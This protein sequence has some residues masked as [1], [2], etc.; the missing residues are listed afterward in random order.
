MNC[1]EKL[2]VYLEMLK[3]QNPNEVELIVNEFPC[4][5]KYAVRL[6]KNCRTSFSAFQKLPQFVISYT[7]ITDFDKFWKDT[8]GVVGFYF[9]VTKRTFVFRRTI[10]SKHNDEM[11]NPV[12]L[13]L[14]FVKELKRRKGNDN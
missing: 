4:L 7:E 2:L 9:S 10:I 6:I 3:L 13:A 12:S 8:F 5:K 1:Y 11:Y 14:K